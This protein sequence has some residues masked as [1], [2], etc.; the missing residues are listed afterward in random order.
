MA[1]AIPATRIPP[2]TARRLRPL[3][4]GSLAEQFRT[5]SG[6]PASGWSGYLSPGTEVP[7]YQ[8]PDYR[9]SSRSGYAGPG[10]AAT[11]D[12][13]ARIRSAQ[14]RRAGVRGSWLAAAGLHGRV[15]RAA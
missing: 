10:Y 12:P 7:G 3:I 15:S 13:Q 4:P 11:A 1:T 8:I 5:P 6:P 2:M 9:D 14:I